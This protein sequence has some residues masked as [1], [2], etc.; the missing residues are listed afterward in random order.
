MHYRHPILDEILL[1]LVER[2]AEIPQYVN[3]SSVAM[4]YYKYYKYCHVYRF[5]FW[6]CGWMLKYASQLGGGLISLQ[7]EHLLYTTAHDPTGS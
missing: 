4:K 1:I 3:L 2:E 7:L 5:R 6:D